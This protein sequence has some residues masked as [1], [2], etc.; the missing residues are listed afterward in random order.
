[1]IK[2][3]NVL[4]DKKKKS[5]ITNFCWFIKKCPKQGEAESLYALGHT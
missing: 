4:F 2:K 5:G 3:E 1:M